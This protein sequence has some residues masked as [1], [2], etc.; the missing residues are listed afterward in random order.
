MAYKSEAIRM[1]Y[2]KQL[3][4]SQALIFSCERGRLCDEKE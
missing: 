2:K 3:K 1:A 4:S